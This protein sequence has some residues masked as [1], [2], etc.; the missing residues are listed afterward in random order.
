MPPPAKM[1]LDDQSSMRSETVSDWG[2]ISPVG[3]NISSVGSLMRNDSID[4][5]LCGNGLTS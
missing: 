2:G 3:S 5:A 1:E 4:V